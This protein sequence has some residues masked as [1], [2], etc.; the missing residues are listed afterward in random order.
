[1]DHTAGCISGALTNCYPVNSHHNANA[2]AAEMNNAL[3][4]ARQL[5]PG[6]PVS[7]LPSFIVIY[8]PLRPVG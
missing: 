3:A 1:M 8:L 2:M 4:M 6:P 5:P 7:L